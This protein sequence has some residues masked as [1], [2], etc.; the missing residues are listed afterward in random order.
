MDKN[1]RRQIGN[2]STRFPPLLPFH[3]VKQLLMT[4]IEGKIIRTSQNNTAYVDI[5]VKMNLC[6]AVRHCAMMKR[7]EGGKSA[8]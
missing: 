8:M 6:K 4:V 2:Q 1:M 7:P 5:Y 3:T